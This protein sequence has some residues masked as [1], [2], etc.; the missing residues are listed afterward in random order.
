MKEIK[1]WALIVWYVLIGAS[2]GVMVFFA[3]VLV[4][5]YSLIRY[6]TF[7]IIAAILLGVFLM[8]VSNTP[9]QAEEAIFRAGMRGV[10]Y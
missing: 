4:T 1:R 5:I 7:W 9:T 6:R 8:D 10:G 2:A 3:A